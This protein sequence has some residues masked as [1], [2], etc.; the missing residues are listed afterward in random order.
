MIIGFTGT[1]AGMT[2]AQKR[3]LAALL[4]KYRLQTVT[5]KP[6]NTSVADLWFHHGDCTGADTEA[7]Y[8]A[9]SYNYKICMHPPTQRHHRAYCKGATKTEHP[10][11]YSVRNHDIVRACDLLIAT[12]KLHKE[13]ARSGTWSTIRYAKKHKKPYIIIYPDGS[14]AISEVKHNADKE[15]AP[16]G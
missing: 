14:K 6:I 7:H 10:Q 2:H 13:E 1:R 3:E 16:Q 8:I 12:P 5:V 11:I 15:T 4:G 9:L